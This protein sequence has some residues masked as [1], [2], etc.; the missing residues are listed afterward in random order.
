MFVI[1]CGSAC[2]LLANLGNQYL[3][4]DEAQTALVSKTILTE[5]VPR[6]YDGKNYFSQEGSAEYGDNYIWRWHTWLPFY[7]L[8]GF[9]KLFG[10]STFVA[11]LPFVLF[12]IGTVLLTYFFAKALWP[13][14][15][16]PA[17][18]AALLAI[19]VPFLLLCRQCRYHSMAMFFSML[20]L[21]A[22][23][24]LLHGR[25]YSAVM[26]FV[27]STLLFHSQHIYVVV[28]FGAV[29]LHAVI[30]GR[31]RLKILLV[32]TFITIIVNA[33]WLVWL[34]GMHYPHQFML[35]SFLNTYVTDIVRYVFPVWLLLVVLIV[36][37]ARRVRTGRFLSGDRRFWERVSLPVFFVTFNV[38][39][40][41]TL[42]PLIFFRYVAPAIPLL[43]LLIAVIVDAAAGVHWLLA[44]ATTAL[45]LATSQL[46]D[47]F[48]EITHDYDGPMKGI[49]RYLNEHGSSEDVVA[50]TY[51]DMPLKFY[52]NMRVIGG[53]TGEDLEP[54]RNAR[55]V[56]IRK[57]VLC[58]EDK[59]VRRYLLKN[60][61]RSKYRKIML[62]S[63]DITWENREDPRN[64]LFRTRQNEDKVVIYE[65]ID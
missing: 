24:A 20:S 64:H 43:I 7:V 21:Y 25:K 51:G 3:W 9:Y 37:F 16:V 41:A 34:A 17:I 6:G 63:P 32:V 19:S 55:W 56:I 27:A 50:I 38:I 44:V 31:P 30:F 2:L 35:I 39:I 60:I 1:M 48:Y 28:L 57:Y 42:S 8:A 46:K 33:P 13:G 62:N 22:Y 12:G 23:V 18:A 10:I 59:K 40:V 15:R 53:L 36:V 11:R 5:G 61:D 49:S 58:S 47:Y 65:R 52:T 14:G 26:L 54:T 45:L 29:L 4:E